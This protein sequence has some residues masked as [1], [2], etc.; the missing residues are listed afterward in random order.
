GMI[1]ET[2]IASGRL[3]AA[4]RLIRADPKLAALQAQAGGRTGG[5]LAVPQ[6][7]ALARLARRLGITISRAAVAANGEEDL[8][9]WVRAAPEG[10]EVALAI[11]GWISRAPRPPAP[12]APRE[13]EADFLRAAADWT[14][15]TD[16]RLRLTALSPGAG[17]AIG[18]PPNTF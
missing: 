17:A 18:S 13:R 4:G 14:W 15:E 5:M 8:D 2:D 7:A 11:T 9:L 10:P 1:G 3:D 12:S 16:D 6:I